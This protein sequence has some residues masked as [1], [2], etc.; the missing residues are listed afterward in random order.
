MNYGVELDLG[1]QYRNRRENFYAGATWGVFW[2]MAALSRPTVDATAPLWGQAE[3]A[4]AAQVL[5]TF[6]GIR[7]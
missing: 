2:P 1:L 6:V 5:R 7:F 3:D 4:S